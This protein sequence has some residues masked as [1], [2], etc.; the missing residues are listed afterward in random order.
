MSP[1]VPVNLDDRPVA[2]AGPAAAL[3]SAAGPAV[4]LQSTAGPAAAPAE[5]VPCSGP[6]DDS[7]ARALSALEAAASAAADVV[8]SDSNMDMRIACIIMSSSI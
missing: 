2:G 1:P 6:F 3:Q 5:A 4:V 8:A 7:G